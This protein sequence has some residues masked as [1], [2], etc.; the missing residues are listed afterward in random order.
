MK[1]VLVLDKEFNSIALV[2]SYIS[3]IWTDRFC[4]YGDFEITTPYAIEML[5]TFKQEYYLWNR[6]SD[7]VMIVEG[8]ELITDA[9]DGNTIIITG[10]SLESILDRRII[11]YQT[12]I[13]GNL[14]NGIKKLLEDN[15]ISPSDNDRKIPNFIFEESTDER[16]TNLTMTGQYTGDSLYDTI[17]SICE[18]N[19]IGFKITLNDSNQFVFKLYLGEDKSF[20]QETN[21]YVVFSPQNENLIEGNYV[22]NLKTLKNVTLVAGEGEGVERKTVTY[23]EASGLTRRELYTDARDI[24]TKTDDD[25]T[26]TPAEYNNALSQRGEEKLAEWKTTKI[27]EGE[28]DTTNMFVYKEDF[29]MGDLVQLR[30]G[31]GVERLARITEIIFSQNTS[32]ETVYPTFKIIDEEEEETE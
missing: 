27:F 6:E 30:S 22:E 7:H 28:L 19:N 11:W 25:V 15:I 9:D 20:N 2:D 10:R 18:A 4:E 26:L 23:G 17:V 14:Q 3:F 16:I 12:N 5:E 24:S 1:T 31:L 8:H 21:P 29:D 32:E 13:D